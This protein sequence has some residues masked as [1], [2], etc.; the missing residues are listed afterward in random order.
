VFGM[1]K[2][3]AVVVMLGIV[4]GTG[5]AAPVT[6]ESDGSCDEAL[7]KDCDAARRQGTSKICTQQVAMNPTS[8]SFAT[9]RRASLTLHVPM[10]V[11]K[12]HSS[13]QTALG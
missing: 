11:P 6:H 7:M 4:F 5:C 8:I 9:T 2:L 13:A 3:A 10:R 12:A 1:K